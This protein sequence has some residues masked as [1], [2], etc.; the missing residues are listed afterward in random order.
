MFVST[1]LFYVLFVSIVLSYV[2]FVSTVLFYVLFVSTVLFYVLFVC[3]CVL[4]YC[5]RVSTQLQLKNI[6]SSLS[7]TIVYLYWLQFILQHCQYPKLYN[8]VTGCL[9]NWKWSGKWQLWPNWLRYPDNCLDRLKKVTQIAELQSFEPGTSWIKD[10]S[11]TTT[12]NCF[13][14]PT[15]ISSA[16]CS[17]YSEWAMDWFDSSHTARFTFP[18]KSRPAFKATSC[19]FYVYWKLFPHGYSG[20]GMQLTFQHQLVLKLRKSGAI[21]L[22]CLLP[23]MVSRGTILTLPFISIT[24]RCEKQ[25]T[26]AYNENKNEVFS[27][28]TNFLN[29][30]LWCLMQNEDPD[31]KKLAHKQTPPPQGI[32]L[33]LSTSCIYSMSLRSK[34]YNYKI[35]KMSSLKILSIYKTPYHFWIFFFSGTTGQLGLRPPHFFIQG[36][37]GGKD[38]TSGGCSLC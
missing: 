22:V 19:L 14:F 26:H 1:V 23:F 5:H 17:Q 10:Q 25:N 9:M 3:K 37:T 35:F 24:F 4:Y 13:A 18:L 2:L 30:N 16:Q 34:I 27:G 6:S 32:Q 20:L 8:Q 38:Q 15:K 11:I 7:F 31:N 33:L 28:S 36:V 21:H 12:P 29:Y